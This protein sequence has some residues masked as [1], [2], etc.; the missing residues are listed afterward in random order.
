MDRGFKRREDMSRKFTKMDWKTIGIGL[1]LTGLLVYIRLL[2]VGKVWEWLL[3]I[4]DYV[5][6]FFFVGVILFV[7][8]EI[9]G[10]QIINRLK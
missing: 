3:G 5:I 10:Y 8:K 9:F 2:L 1:L 7:F 4:Y 6:A